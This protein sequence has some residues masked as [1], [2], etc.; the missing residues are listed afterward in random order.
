V[1]RPA[2]PVVEGVSQ[3]TDDGNPKVL[4]ALVSDGSRIYFN[5]IRDGTAVIAQVATTGGESGLVTQSIPGSLLMAY[6]SD[7]PHLLVRDNAFPGHLWILPL[8]AGEPRKL[9][10]FE[11]TDDATLFPN[12]NIVFVNLGVLYLAQGGGSDPHKLFSFPAYVDGPVVSPD[13]R[14]I[15][16]NLWRNEL[17]REIWEVNS[18]GSNP[19][20]VLKDWQGRFDAGG[21][22]WTADGAYFIFQSRRQGRSDLWVLPERTRRFGGEPPPIRLTNGP[23]SYELPF[24]SGDGKHLYVIGRKQRGELVRYDRNSQQFVPFLSGISAADATVS[25]DGKWVAYAS[26]P[27]HSLWRSRIDGSDRLRL[28]YPPTWV[29]YPRISPDGTK[30]A[31]GSLD[32][33]GHRAAYLISSDGG[34][35]KKIVENALFGV[36]W[37]P[38]GNSVVANVGTSAIESLPDSTIQITDLRTGATQSVPDS[39]GRGGV[40]WPSLDMLLAPGCR[41]KCGFYTFNFT[42]QKWSYLVYAPCDHWIT[43][44]DGKFLYYTTGLVDPKIM[45]IRF[46][47][48]KVEEIKSLKDFRRIEDE[49]TQSWL[50]VT[51]DGDPLL[52]RDIGTDEIYDISLRWP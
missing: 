27:D 32:E 49:I 25:N 42:T 41:P 36:N 29:S 5:E 22:R 16:V 13:G 15:R 44:L 33:Q 2:T 18:D 21:G 47:D 11:V 40:W 34:V 20:P 30:V 37:S 28:T 12:G 38:D 1:S 48:G 43:S 52:T 51:P 35:S 10:E 8:P 45:R 23:L 4:S 50:G 39:A 6:A 7:P 46:S 19:H 17:T 24:S 14:R 31:F 3:I 9:A 26:Y